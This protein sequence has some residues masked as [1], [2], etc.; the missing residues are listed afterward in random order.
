MA[1]FI[2]GVD[3]GQA[4]LFPDRLEDW[5]SE[6][7]LVRVVDLSLVISICRALGLVGQVRRGQGDPA[8]IRRFCSSCSFAGI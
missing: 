6:D 5:I 3:R 4:V 2:E 1:G 7:S 8:A